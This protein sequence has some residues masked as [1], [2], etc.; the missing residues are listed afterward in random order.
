MRSKAN[1]LQRMLRHKKWYLTALL[2]LTLLGC[3][4]GV[5]LA[6]QSAAPTA[7][8]PIPT[9]TPT[10][11]LLP[12]PAAEEPGPAADLPNDLVLVDALGLDFAEK[13]VMEV[14]E[15]VSPAVVNVTTQ[16]LRRS[17]FFEAIPEEGAGSGFVIDTDGHIVTNFHVIEGAQRI[18]VTFIDEST[19]PAEI[20]GADRRNDIAVLRVES[21]PSGVVPVELGRSTSLEVG[22]RAIAI[23]NPFGQFGSTLTTG[24]VS[25][26]DRTLESQDGRQMSGIIQTDA[27]INR[28]NSGGPLLDSAGRV[29]GINSAIFSPSGTSAGVGFAIPVDTLH[30]L[31]PDL[32]ALGRYRHPWLGVRYGYRITPGLADILELPV[33]QGLLLVELFRDG[34]LAS[35]GVLGAQREVILGN[36]RVFAGG[37]ILMAIDGEAV[38]SIESLQTIL[39]TKYQVGDEVGLNLLRNGQPMNVTVTLGEEPL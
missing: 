7:T 14:Y 29:I 2:V 30:R 12:T 19:I 5:S 22:Q 32:L 31:L 6:P 26:L 4:L 15:R 39:E 36:Q 34:P 18:E 13:R 17:F 27:A 21:L 24:V 10:P 28:G 25:A 38:T 37:D 1:F 35:N 16:V 9:A 23:G 8:I 11:L 20:V 3:Q 33:D